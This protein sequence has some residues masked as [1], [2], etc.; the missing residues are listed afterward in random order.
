MILA[1]VANAQSHPELLDWL[2]TRIHGS[3][4]EP[5]RDDPFDP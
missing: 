3:W 1:F 5:Q 2:A 4:L